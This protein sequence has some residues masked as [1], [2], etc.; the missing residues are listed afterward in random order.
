MTEQE[1]LNYAYNTVLSVNKKTLLSKKEIEGVHDLYEPS[2]K[3]SKAISN[4]AAKGKFPEELFEHRSPNQTEKEAEYIKKNFKQ[5]TL[6]V[7][8]DYL[9]TITR[10]FG[11]GNWSIKYKEDKDE[12]KSNSFQS[13]VESGIPIYGSLEQFIKFILPTIKSIDANGF[14]GIRPRYIDY[15]EDT[16]GELRIDDTKLFEPTIFYYKSKQVIDFNEEYVLFLSDEHSRVDYAGKIEESGSIYELYT[17]EAVYFIV[18]VGKKVDNKFELRPFY[19]HNL[20]YIPAHQLMGI[21]KIEDD[22]LLWQSPFIYSV[23]LLDLVL[24]NSNWLQA[25]INKCVFPNVVMYGSPCEFR[26]SEGHACNGGNILVEG[27][28][29]TCPSCNGS[30][31]KSRLSPLGTL[32]INPAT[33]FDAGE[34]NATQDPLRFISPDVTTLEFLRDKISEDTDKARKILHLQTSNSEVKGSENMTA[35]GMAIDAKS[36]YSFVKPI[37]D[38]IFTLYEFCLKTIGKERYGDKFEGVELS[39]P[40]TFDFKSAEDYL[41]DISNAIK[42]NLPPSF[43]QTILLQYINA[44]YGDNADT[45]KIFKL[46]SEVDRLFS[47]SQDDINMKLAKGTVAKWEDIL[48]GSIMMFISNEIDNN[49]KFLELPFEK[50]KEALINKAKETQAEIEGKPIDDLM[51]AITPIDAGGNAL[52]QSVGGLTGMIEIAKAVAS[53]LYDLDAA[54]ALVQ[55][56]FGLTEEEARRQLGTPQQIQSAQEADKIAKLT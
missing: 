4:H 10:P 1:I 11:D 2:V 52:K 48:H 51:A 41:N 35:T 22:K 42:N 56:R 27:I 45:T 12:F 49:D 8:V 25:S 23:D 26:D 17:K 3:M 43:I 38:Q 39:Y 14:I 31:L 24:V 36:M 28:E 50:Q 7:F 47:Y 18:Q 19:Q 29:K 9:S 6:P 20:G 21:P 16:T 46:V 53:G 15:I 33:K 44:F 34:V 13:Y 30:G 55:D 5:H 54:A 37:S 40:K 32:L